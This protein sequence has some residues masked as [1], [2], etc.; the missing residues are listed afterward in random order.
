MPTGQEVGSYPCLSDCSGSPR[1]D[2][3]LLLTILKPKQVAQI[4]AVGGQVLGFSQSGACPGKKGSSPCLGLTGSSEK[5]IKDKNG[6][7]LTLKEFEKQGGREASRNWKKSV[8][9]YG[10][11]LEKLIRVF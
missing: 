10:Q 8:R 1:G 3:A 6:M 2:S 7:W 5:C 11:T 4:H 9:C